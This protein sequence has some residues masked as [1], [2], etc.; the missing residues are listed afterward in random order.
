[1]ARNSAGDGGPGALGAG[2]QAEHDTRGLRIA[3]HDLERN[4][5]SPSFRPE[6]G[7]PFGPRRIAKRSESLQWTSGARQGP[8]RVDASDACRS[9][10]RLALV[11]GDCLLRDA[12]HHLAAVEWRII[13]QLEHLEQMQLDGASTR[14][15][16]A[17]LEALRCGR[18]A[19]DAR[20]SELLDKVNPEAALSS[21]A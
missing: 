21:A 18:D 20:R 9:T 16:E 10:D 5:L 7:A 17:V 1:M 19:W 4:T 13:C 6:V 15:A 2:F 11:P 14:A 3:G 8:N 12:E